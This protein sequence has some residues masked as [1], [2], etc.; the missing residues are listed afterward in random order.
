MLFARLFIL[1]VLLA[2]AA[3]SDKLTLAPPIWDGND[4]QQPPLT[5]DSSFYLATPVTPALARTRA[6]IVWDIME[7]W[8]AKEDKRAMVQIERTRWV[9]HAAA[10][11]G[12][13]LTI[14]GRQVFASQNWDPVPALGS[15]SLTLTGTALGIDRLWFVQDKML[16]EICY[17][18][19]PPAPANVAAWHQNLLQVARAVQAR[20][21]A[22][23][24]SGAG[25]P[26]EDDDNR[27]HGN[28]PDHH[29]EDNPGNGSG[30]P[31]KPK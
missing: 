10:I 3:V 5:R 18:S 28:D 20:I 29:D 15:H 6:G 16:V 31:K 13:G 25:Q 9:S 30:K 14:V 22:T 23:G 7:F 1:V 19:R 12:V 27:G 26:D 11:R 21:I 17:R 2:C 8:Y 24:E 4:G